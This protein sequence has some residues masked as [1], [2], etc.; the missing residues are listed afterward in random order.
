MNTN[1]TKL[2]VALH[3]EILEA[4]QRHLETRQLRDMNGNIYDS[5]NPINRHQMFPDKLAKRLTPGIS[6]EVLEQMEEEVTATWVTYKGFFEPLRVAPIPDMLNLVSQALPHWTMLYITFDSFRYVAKYL[7]EH[8]K[9]EHTSEELAAILDSKGIT[10]KEVKAVMDTMVSLGGLSEHNGVYT[11]K[12]I[13][14]VHKDPRVEE[15]ARDYLKTALT[16]MSL[17]RVL[18]EKYTYAAEF[19]YKVTRKSALLKAFFP[20][21]SLFHIFS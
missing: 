21:R 9:Q 14:Y 20:F 16:A 6:S 10:A 1:D 4:V 19:E 15:V 8:V 13:D 2:T 11:V 7:G 17:Y 18:R 12:T 5:G 3:H